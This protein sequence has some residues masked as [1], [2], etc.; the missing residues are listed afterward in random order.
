MARRS[1]S[2]PRIGRVWR[3]RAPCRPV[4]NDSRGQA[5]RPGPVETEAFE[6]VHRSVITTIADFCAP[7]KASRRSAPSW[8]P[9]RMSG[10]THRPRSL[11][12]VATVGRP[13]LLAL[14]SHF[15]WPTFSGVQH[16]S[17]SSASSVPRSGR[18]APGCA[19]TCQRRRHG[20][21]TG[22]NHITYSAIRS[23]TSCQCRSLVSRP[24]ARRSH[25]RRGRGQLGPGVLPRLRKPIA[26]HVA[27]FGNLASRP[28][29]AG[30]R[31]SAASRTGHHVA[32][33]SYILNWPGTAAQADT[34]SSSPFTACGPHWRRI[35]SRVR[36]RT[37]ALEA[38]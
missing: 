25:S 18:A 3:H 19:A 17:P 23:A 26:R 24:E 32:P 34:E 38:S 37:V 7:A 14:I 4:T 35:R 30:L 8:R 15:R 9:S 29:R 12:N 2:T 22:M 16:L 33:V 13:F 20:W 10:T 5:G 36:V 1:S 21:H 11:F 27:A 31:R 6:R 28:G